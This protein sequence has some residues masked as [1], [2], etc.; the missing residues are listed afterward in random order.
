MSKVNDDMTIL[1]I[2]FNNQWV[3]LYWSAMNTICSC[4]EDVGFHSKIS[5]LW[6]A[7]LFCFCLEVPV[8]ETHR[9]LI[10]NMLYLKQVAE[11]NLDNLKAATLMWKTKCSGQPKSFE[12]IIESRYYWKKIYVQM[13]K[14][15]SE[16]LNMHESIIIKYLWPFK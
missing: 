12:L 6:E 14:E 3:T 8:N 13:F 11:I 16:T 5:Y 1:S 10:R 15:S 4:T 7:L 2:C 9:F